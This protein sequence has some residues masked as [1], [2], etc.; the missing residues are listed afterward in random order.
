MDFIVH[1]KNEKKQYRAILQISNTLI[2]DS[3]MH[4]LLL[5]FIRE[6]YKN[7]CIKNFIIL[8]SSFVFTDVGAIEGLCR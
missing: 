1:F 4:L 5:A 3:L 2:T 8:G 7:L 6:L